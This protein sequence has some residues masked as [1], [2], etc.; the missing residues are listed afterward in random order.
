MSLEVSCTSISKLANFPLLGNFP[1][2][3]GLGIAQRFDLLDFQTLADVGFCFLL[4]QGLA[5]LG[6]F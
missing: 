6:H 4:I 5:A 1:R 3:C 2:Y